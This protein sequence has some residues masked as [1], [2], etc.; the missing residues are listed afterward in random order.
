M[1]FFIAPAADPLKDLPP[2]AFGDVLSRFAQNIANVWLP[3]FVKQIS[4]PFGEYMRLLA[5]FVCSLLSVVAFLKMLQK[6]SGKIEDFARFGV[7]L[8]L[9]MILIGTGQSLSRDAFALGFGLSRGEAK[10]VVTGVQIEDGPVDS[11]KA[12]EGGAYLER[13]RLRFRDEF[14]DAYAQ[15]V[16]KGFMI[17][18]SD[19]A[20]PSGVRTIRD[21]RPGDIDWIGTIVPESGDRDNAY[22]RDL[23]KGLNPDNWSPR[24]LFAALNGTR[25]FMESGFLFLNL[26]FLFLI[27]TLHIVSPMVAATAV[28]PDLRRQIAY[29][30]L[31]GLITF[32]IVFPFVALFLEI[33]SYKFGAIAL[34]GFTGTADGAGAP[35]QLSAYAWDPET[36]STIRQADPTYHLAIGVVLMALCGLLMW[37]SPFIAF[38]FTQGRIFEA[39]VS[40]VATLATA[41][42]AAGISFVSAAGGVAATRA[43]EGV[44]N[45]SEFTTSNLNARA[46]TQAQITNA[47][48]AAANQR[49]QAEGSRRAAQLTMQA[50]VGPGG[51]NDQRRGANTFAQQQSER[52]GY[53]ERNDS[54][55]N[56]GIEAFGRLGAV[57]EPLPATT[58]Q[59]NHEQRLMQ[60]KLDNQASYEISNRESVVSNQ[61]A[62][63]QADAS[64]AG[65]GAQYGASVRAANIQENAALQGNQMRFDANEQAARL[66]ALAAMSNAAGSAASTVAGSLE[67][68]E[69]F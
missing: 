4:E 60:V 40:P 5:F 21:P 36:L 53:S 48:G 35:S 10:A 46:A 20:I 37:V 16:E 61:A 14:N 69:K 19:P 65:A 67:Q 64:V 13:V 34:L 27:P 58:A 2:L 47:A 55:L 28:D 6:D 59:D 41:A 49:L 24:T 54:A 56:N 43:A 39:I 50:Y 62:G 63:I 29:P 3:E 68:L 11:G 15:F 26:L 45:Q 44:Q 9:S 32:S 30:Y 57:G 18:V 8:T 17:R 52:I 33:A 25:G 1:F 7:A 23:V 12:Y 31:K 66:R 51:I 22:I 42:T 38:G